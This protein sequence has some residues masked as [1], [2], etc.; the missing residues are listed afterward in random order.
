[1]F[2]Y[3]D[4]EYDLVYLRNDLQGEYDPGDF[5]RYRRSVS[6][7]QR[8]FGEPEGDVLGDRFATVFVFESATGVHLSVPDGDGGI[9]ASF[10][11]AVGTELH[12]FVSDCRAVVREA[13]ER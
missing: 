6:E 4:A 11:S 7:S 5:E 8:A 13:R 12:R 3:D 9:V 2:A 1:V 10:D